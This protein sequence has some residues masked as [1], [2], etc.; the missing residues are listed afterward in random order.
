[1]KRS[2]L[3]SAG[4]SWDYSKGDPPFYPGLYSYSTS[5]GFGYSDPIAYD[6][7]VYFSLF[8]GDGYLFAVDGNT[9]KLKWKFTRGREAISS[10]TIA[11]GVLYVAVGKILHAIELSSQREIWSYTAGAAIPALQP[12]L[13]VEGRVYIGS[14]DGN[15]VALDAAR[16]KEKWSFKAGHEASWNSMAYSDGTLFAIETTDLIHALKVSVPQQLWTFQSPRTAWFPVVAGDRLYF[17]DDRG[18]I[19]ALDIRDGKPKPEFKKKNQTPTE[20]AIYEG[21]IIF[22]GWDTGS[23]FAADAATGERD[24][25]FENV[26]PCRAPTVAGGTVYVTCDDQKLYALDAANGKKSWSIDTK[27]QVMS[28]PVVANGAVYFIADDGKVHAVK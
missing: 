26:L 28:A 13:V 16:G 23:I 12:P 27:Q 18:N 21:K 5:F 19:N 4:T 11:G 3:G 6:G 20:F 7:V 25:K 15:I 10:P 17:I 22:G 9:G 14:D 1:M 2:A 8:L 24:W